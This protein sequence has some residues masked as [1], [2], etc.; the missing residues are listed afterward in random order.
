MP[1]DDRREEGAD[2]LE[3]RPFSLRVDELDGIPETGKE[4]DVQAALLPDLSQ[5]CLLR[6]L[7]RFDATSGKKHAL[8]RAHDR[9]MAVF[10][11]DDGVDAWA[12]H[13]R[14]PCDTLAAR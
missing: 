3:V 7:V 6:R 10:V 13:V 2:L 12:P 4:A 1:L 14:C 11:L 8:R 9:H 5:R